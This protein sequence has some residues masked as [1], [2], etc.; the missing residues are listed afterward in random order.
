MSIIRAA[1]PQSRFYV[2]DKSISEDRRLSWAAR[3]LLVFLLGKPD[4]WEVSV[5]NLVN[6][7]SDSVR[8]GGHTKRDGV[9]AVLAEL[10]AAG[11]MTRSEKPRH[12]ADGSFAGYDYIVS[13]VP[14]PSPSEPST[15][16]PETAGPST[17]D[18]TQ[19]SNEAKQELKQQA[20]KERRAP[21]AGLTL[22]EWLSSCKASGEK[23]IP[24]S[25]PVFDYA[26]KQK[27]PL[28]Y[29][30]YAWLE[31]RRKY[32]DGGK[33]QKDWRAHFR[34]AV[35]ENWYSIWFLKDGDFVLTTRGL[36]IQR[37]HAEAA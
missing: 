10:N 3:G 24:E 27:L 13:E 6:E 2:L 25:D 9:K 8:V 21:R 31:F 5:T 26:D 34:N 33:K 4:H 36:Q 37:E 35:R 12:N 23:P 17:A 30:R 29:V 22:A 18:P 14:S 16:E 32:G 15:V 28:E 19:V 7:T 11:Y 1:R 20:K